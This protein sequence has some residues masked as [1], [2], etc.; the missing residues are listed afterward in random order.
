MT[1]R[2]TAV[3]SKAMSLVGYHDL[4]RRPA[5]K[6]AAQEVGGRFYLYLSHFW[7]AGWSV[8]DVTEPESPQLLDFVA[9]SSFDRTWT[10][11]V[12]VADGL[13]IGSLER[14][15]EGMEGAPYDAYDEG[16]LLF[17]VATDPSHP[18]Q[19]GRFRTGGTG[20]H[21]NFY[22]GGRYA[23]LTAVLDGFVGRC[24]VVLDVDDPANPK[25]VTRWWWPGQNVAAGET[26]EHAPIN[27][28]HGPAYVV[29]DRA[30]VSYGRIGALIMDVS[31]P[32][33][34]TVISRVDVG[35]I[36]GSLGC[37][38]AIPIL[39]RGLL[40]INSEAIKEGRAE[41][42]NYAFVV[43]ISDE[44][45]PRI[46][47][48]LP[49]PVP[50][51]GAPYRTYQDKGGRFGP[52]NQAHR[53]GMPVYLPLERH[54]LMTWFNAGLRLYDIED[55]FNPVEVAHHVAED[56]A[57]RLGAL[58]RTALVTQAEDVAVDRRGYIYCTDKNWGL[59]VLRYDGT[60]S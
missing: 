43:D 48:S 4:D 9:T 58:P 1:V 6:I 11:Q 47:G 15:Y 16:V 44:E 42:L 18:A 10:T 59:S 55:P 8:V 7:H 13:M 29:G 41:G 3:E 52:H 51:E 17:D 30:Y 20:T 25:E 28:M 31:D 49:T 34:P 46:V 22:A 12:Q 53:Q 37:H 38:S 14:P 60:L 54:V 19:V 27:Y 45:R 40:V 33:S 32:A 36:G 26:P 24:L 21:R 23:Y 39:S 5:F 50:S 2:P 57:E 35:D 56:P